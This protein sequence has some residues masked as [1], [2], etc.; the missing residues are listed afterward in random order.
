MNEFIPDPIE[1]GEA[2]AEEG[3]D[4]LLQPNGLFKCYS[5]D[6]VFDTDKE[7]GTID[8]S[9]WAMP[10]CGKCLEDAIKGFDKEAWQKSSFRGYI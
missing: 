1:R 9:P 4:S 5:C 7:G 3:Y 2:S 8:P 10:V 6:A